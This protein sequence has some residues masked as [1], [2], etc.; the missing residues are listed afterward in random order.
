M[1]TD[2]ENVSAEALAALK[3]DCDAAHAVYSTRYAERENAEAQLRIEGQRHS[4][5]IARRRQL[6]REIAASS[7]RAVEAAIAD[8]SSAD[9]SEL[10]KLRASLQILEKAAKQQEVFSQADAQ[11]AVW[12]AKVAEL[13]AQS[14]LQELISRV[15]DM[16]LTLSLAAA[17]DL[18]GGDLQ[19][20]EF[21]GKSEALSELVSELNQQLARTRE[22]LRQHTQEAKIA[23]D[24]FEKEGL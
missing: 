21:G 5:I 3:R 20:S 13:A 18:N 23:R 8:P 19:V 17:S 11:T 14:E 4:A 1:T 22:R 6:Q 16:E 12:I 24:A 15:H 9:G 2:I 7:K 10:V